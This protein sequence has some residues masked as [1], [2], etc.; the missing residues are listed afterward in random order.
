MK[1]EKQ[2]K[3]M[4][5]DDTSF[6]DFYDYLQDKDIGD[7]DSI[8]SE[9]IIKQ[10]LTEMIGKGIHVSHIVKALEET[11]SSEDLYCIWLG[12]SMETPTPINNKKDLVEALEIEIK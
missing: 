9:D 5:E 10:Y 7:W 4:L 3:K 11:T 6:Q 2:I 1:E 12:N 8:N